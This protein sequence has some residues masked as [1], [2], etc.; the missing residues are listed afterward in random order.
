MIFVFGSNLDGNHAGGAALFARRHRGAQLGVGEGLVGNSYA[1][2]TVGHNF[3][4][5]SLDEIEKH[6]KVFLDFARTRAD[7][8][9]ALTPV[10][11]GLAGHKREDI[12]AILQKHGV[13]RNVYLT[14]TWVTE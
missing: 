4:R 11:C 9:F 14:G 1:L 12:W 7:L 2:P 10:G 5:M 6:V 8:E 13:P 3:V